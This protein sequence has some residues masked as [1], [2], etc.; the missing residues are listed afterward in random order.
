MQVV[1]TLCISYQNGDV[2]ALFLLLFIRVNV[3][4][5]YGSVLWKVESR[6]E[7]ILMLNGKLVHYPRK[8]MR[9]AKKSRRRKVRKISLNYFHKKGML[10]RTFRCLAFR[11]YL[12]RT[13]KPHKLI[14]L[15]AQ[16]SSRTNH[17][18]LLDHLS[19]WR[20]KNDFSPSIISIKRWMVIGF[21][22]ALN[23]RVYFVGL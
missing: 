10:F 19:V 17:F 11:A 9:S 21:D 3:G 6:I 13:F 4:E 1:S 2:N 16:I 20:C 5:W 8:R 23:G 12:H 15:F 14:S 22:C 18:R 7:R